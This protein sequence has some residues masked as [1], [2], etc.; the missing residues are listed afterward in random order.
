MVDLGVGKLPGLPGL[1]GEQ[2]FVAVLDT[3]PLLGQ[4][5]L[6][7]PAHQLTPVVTSMS[8]SAGTLRVVT[9][10]GNIRDVNTWEAWSCRHKAGPGPWRRS[11]LARRPWRTGRESPAP[12]GKVV[13]IV[14]CSILSQS[15]KKIRVN[16]GP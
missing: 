15:Q 14:E 2:D 9:N 7:V 8:S 12:G 1:L 11:S 10:Q 5:L 16:F 6:V 13:W 3:L 4:E